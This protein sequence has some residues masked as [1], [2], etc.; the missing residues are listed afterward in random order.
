MCEIFERQIAPRSYQFEHPEDPDPRYATTAWQPVNEA[1][2]V[3]QQLAIADPKHLLTYAKTIVAAL[4]SGSVYFAGTDAGR[5]AVDFVSLKSDGTR[6]F[7]LISQNQFNDSMYAEYLRATTG[8]NLQN[9]AAEDQAQAFTDYLN[10]ARRRLKA[11]QLRPG[12]D[13]QI[14]NNQVQVRGQIAVMEIVSRVAQILFEKNQA[15][16]FF[17]DELWPFDW[18]RPLAEPCGFILKINRNPI[19]E[20]S[21]EVIRKDREFWEQRAANTIGNWPGDRVS[22]AETCQWVER[23]YLS[24]DTNGFS[25]DV[26]FISTASHA[27]SP[28]DIYGACVV[29][30]KSRANIAGLY[31]WRAMN[32]K[33][34]R[35]KERMIVE[36][37]F[38]YRPA[39][40]LG[41]MQTTTVIQYC[42]FLLANNREK[43]ALVLV[44]TAG[45]FRPKDESFMAV[46]NQVS[47]WIQYTN[48]SKQ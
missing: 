45:K 23:V 40:A 2:F 43:D 35:E 11:N 48:K 3:Y 46:V 17:I 21:E 12:E 18:V 1:H 41:P 14:T 47:N 38:A 30:S 7:T 10:D 24:G 31:H 5:F 15:K 6:L 34:E 25:G 36:T 13:V 22:V 26:E 16:E 9:L 29:Y 20:L 37:N 32:A 27:Y 8:T 33:S 19:G 28:S 44:Q 42:N 4:P 39:F